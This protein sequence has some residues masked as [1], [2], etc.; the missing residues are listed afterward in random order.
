MSDF[1]IR[2]ED[3]KDD[4]ILGFYVQ[5]QRDKQIVEQLKASTPLVLEGSRGTGKSFLLRVAKA[6][7]LLS[8]TQDRAFPVY[9]SFAKSSL[10]HSDDPD[11]FLHWMLAKL[12]SE[13]LRA[14]TKKGLLFRPPVVASILAGGPTEPPGR[15]YRVEEIVK[16][17]EES[18][19][20][21]GVAV[22][23]V[24]V[25][26][27][28]D[29]K[30]GVEELCDALDISRLVILFDEAVHI[31]RPEQQRQFFTLFRDLRS[32]YINCN[33]AVYP[34]VTSYGPTFQLAH[35][36]TVAE[37]NRSLLDADYRE[38]M[39][40][41]VLKQADAQLLTNIERHKENFSALA[42]AVSGN[43]RLLL[44]TVAKAP[45]M[46][47][48]EVESVL[49]NFY[50][51]EIWSEHSGLAETYEGHRTLIDWGRKFIENTVIPDTKAK[52][53]QWE[54]EGKTESTCFFWIHRDAPEPVK[55]ALRLLAYTGIVTKLDSGIAATRGEIGT[56][57]AVNTGCLSATQPLPIPSITKIVRQLT[58]RRFTEFGANAPAFAGL[59][60]VTG[61]FQVPDMS[62]VL[63]TQLTKSVRVL[64]ITDYQKE[65]L[66]KLGF[67]TIGK[68]LRAKEE[69]FQEADY[70]GP[71]RSRRMMNA[72]ISSVLEYLS[73]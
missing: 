10:V 33:A 15:T 67:D 31:F 37:I 9:V 73:G 32:P 59:V 17:Y 38:S 29:F 55:E 22:S 44:K 26:T 49:K 35:D 18:Y 58:A 54:G 53:Q 1:R 39:L 45:K 24:G 4:E 41:I 27:V 70:I 8:Y 3:I 34:G 11:Q 52:N 50:R 68:A 19:R 42:Y 30:N 65:C 48:G 71:V 63:Q 47:S 13:I 62:Q 23:A 60:N 2:T 64:D 16:A 5:T 57:Y 46:T 43:P 66:R 6:Q 36:A 51:T 25:P 40:D 72:V 14:L 7:L 20:N 69:D 56:R 28:D 12:S 61:T 21:P